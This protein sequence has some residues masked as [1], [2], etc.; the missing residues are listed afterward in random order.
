M[1]NEDQII[2]FLKMILKDC[3][4]GELMITKG[5]IEG[6]RSWFPTLIGN[7]IP[8]LSPTIDTK[9]RGALFPKCTIANANTRSR[10]RDSS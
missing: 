1:S 10:L 3:T 2:T 4:N 5:S 6:D 9:E 7:V 8:M